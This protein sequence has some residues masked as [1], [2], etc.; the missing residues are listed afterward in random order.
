M[1]V[2]CLKISTSTCSL[3]VTEC[4]ISWHM[5]SFNNQKKG[6]ELSS[7]TDVVFCQTKAQP[8]YHDS[9]YIFGSTL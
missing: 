9:V 2:K 1:Y 6:Y 3:N 4:N 7:A 5:F 8:W